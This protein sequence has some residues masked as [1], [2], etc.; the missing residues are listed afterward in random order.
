MRLG[1]AQTVCPLVS[2]ADRA[3]LAAI[4]ADRNRP[5]K[6]AQRARIILTSAER[7]SVLEVA[8]RSGATRPAVWRWQQRFA[9]AGVDGLLR[10]RTRK[11]GKPRTADAVVQRVVALT[12]AEP[13]GEA[14]HWTGRAMARASGLSLRTVQRI[15]AAHDLQPHRIRSFKR[16]RDPEF[17]AKLEDIVGLYLAPPKHAIVLSVDEKS[18]IQ[19]LD[20]TQPGLPIKPGKAGT[21]THDY[22]RHGTTTLFAALNVLDGTVIGRCMQ[23]HR[24][25]ASRR[26]PMSEGPPVRRPARRH[27]DFIRFLNAVEAAVPAGKLVH[28]IL[29]NY[30]THK[31]PKVRAWLA[32]HPRWTFHHTPTS[33]SWLNAVETFFSA[34]TRRRLRR[35]VFRSLVDLQAAIHRYLAE[36]NAAPKPFTWTATPAKI[37]AKLDHVNASMH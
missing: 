29:D 20:C 16:S 18:Q 21:M 27:Q 37:I 32:R 26:D 9:E 3:R 23:R 31:H 17:L 7:L 22:I 19:A 15:W 6:H 24:A 13:P 34:M 2:A 4:A 35:G 33:C 30:A 1:M 8:R 10:D 12:C 11:P 14:T 25:A 28:A 36:H 5:Q